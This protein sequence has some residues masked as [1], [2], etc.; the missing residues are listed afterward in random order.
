ML[1]AVLLPAALSWAAQTWERE[2]NYHFLAKNSKDHFSAK[3]AG[4]NKFP[5]KYLTYD[6][7]K[8]L[9]RAPA[10]R[11]DYGRLDLCGNKNFSIPVPA[12]SRVDEVHFL[13]GG[14]YGNNY[15]DDP[16]LK[17]YG[18]NYYY[19]VIS[20]LFVYE[21]GSF[22]SLS[23][24]VFWDWF[25]LGRREWSGDGA[26]IKGLGNNPVRKDC[27]MYHLSFNNP[28]PEKPLR[29][30]LVSDSWLRDFPFSDVFALTVK[31]GDKLE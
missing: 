28:Y 5:G 6:K 8:F 22:R 9:V 24:P 2:G 3:G 16:L 10:N 15:N 30:I 18:E 14:S 12:G 29:S 23:V 1:V 21:D 19:S 13:A 11:E 17:L 26:K 20:V 25:H 31:S 27:S 7:I 4:P